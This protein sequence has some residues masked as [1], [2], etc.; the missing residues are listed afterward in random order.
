MCANKWLK[1]YLSRKW[2]NSPVFASIDSINKRSL[3]EHCSI[4]AKNRI[5]VTCTLGINWVLFLACNNTFA[6][7]PWSGWNDVTDSVS[8]YRDV[9]II[10][11]SHSI[12]QVTPAREVEEM[13][14]LEKKEQMIVEWRWNGRWPTPSRLWRETL[15]TGVMWEALWTYSCLSDHVGEKVWGKN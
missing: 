9:K 5:T 12:G 8:C 4:V 2:E 7:L 15:P 10:V 14:W 1:Q 11:P 13:D 6:T 3:T